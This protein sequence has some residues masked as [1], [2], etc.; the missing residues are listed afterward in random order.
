MSQ[1]ESNNFFDLAPEP[2]A[3]IGADGVL[4][5]A[6]AAFRHILGRPG[7][8]L[9]CEGTAGFVHAEDLERWRAGMRCIESAVGPAAVC[10]RCKTDTGEWRWIEWSCSSAP[11]GRV[12]AAA[13]DVTFHRS[14]SRRLAQ[15]E[16]QMDAA[17]AE[18]WLL[19][20][21]G[22]VVHANAYLCTL[23]G[24][25]ES[26]MIGKRREDIKPGLDSQE[27]CFAETLH[28]VK[29]GTPVWRSLE[30]WGTEG[31]W[32]WTSVDKV[33]LHG[34][35]DSVT[36]VVVFA[37]EITS[38]IQA[39]L[40]FRR[41]NAELEHRVALRTDELGAANSALRASEERTRAILANALD[42][43]VMMNRDGLVTGWNKAAERIFG[44]TAEEAMSREVAGLI[45]P[46]DGRAP[47]RMGLAAARETGHGPAIGRLVE[48]TAMRKSGEQFPVE[49]S[50]TGVGS[51]RNIEFTAFIRDIS[52]RKESQN[53]ILDL[54][55]QLEQRVEEAGAANRELEA[56]CYSVSH[57][58]RT[59]LRSIDGFS[60]ALVEDYG[61]R[62]DE[63]GRD[64]MGR[65]RSATQRM[66]RL[67]DDLLNLSRVSR[68]E[69]KRE[70]ANL[71]AIASQIA[72]DIR[73]RDPSRNCE[74]E[75]QPGMETKG[76]PALLGIVLENLLNNAWK[77]TSRRENARIE[78][79]VEERNGRRIFHVRDNG[80]GFD[81][82]Y[83]D[84]LFAPFQRLHRAD[85]FEGSGVGLATVQRILHR[86]GGHA[87]AEAEVDKGATIFFTL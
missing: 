46:K 63:T 69:M 62:L 41:L 52:E 66:A 38:Q 84:K 28:V 21:D 22:R 80:A 48:V 47:H 4:L 56:F 60:M 59:P 27:E 81:M 17:T 35:D 26:D 30:R 44:W 70:S 16:S 68:T 65:V 40:E 39:E 34:D 42:A 10:V 12:F 49:L 76:D 72:A 53:R 32:R 54:N 5:E 31:D 11:G 67:I 18:V 7:S 19:D 33:P 51:G 45:I 36:N 13:R 14:D 50:I 15:L 3:V 87:W 57:D 29:S 83:A 2:L 43:V 37:Y 75:I 71:S 58:L 61:E 6:N 85:E 74:I 24:I 79:A 73:E 64:Y 9:V 82:A 1:T 20:C 23:L 86:H 55:N 8:E 78:F 25:P 77:Y